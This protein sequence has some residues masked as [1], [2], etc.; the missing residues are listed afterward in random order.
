M[1][2]GRFSSLGI[3]LKNV[4]KSINAYGPYVEVS[5]RS[6]RLFLK[7]GRVNFS[8]IVRLNISECDFEC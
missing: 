8:E 3:H 7:G 5:N 2:V 4:S 6:L 1:F